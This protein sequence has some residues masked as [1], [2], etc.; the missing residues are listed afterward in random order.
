MINLPSVGIRAPAGRDGAKLERFTLGLRTRPMRMR[1]HPLIRPTGTFSPAGRRGRPAPPPSGEPDAAVR[2]GRPRPD[3]ERDG[4]RGARV[5]KP[6]V[7][8]SSLEA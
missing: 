4:V 2:A 7:K 5:R 6:T 1:N 8:R 3:G